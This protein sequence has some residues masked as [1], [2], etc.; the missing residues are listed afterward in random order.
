MAHFAELDTNNVVTRVIVVGNPDCLD[1]NGQESE[2]AGIAFCQSLF[3]ADTRWVQTSYNGN[4]RGNYAAVGYTYDEQLDAF[5]P[6]KPYPS[7]VLNEI[8]ITWEAPV[9]M[10]SDG[11]VYVWDEANQAW[12]TS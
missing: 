2:A 10:P 7:W 9:P 6:I 8:T 4:M 11:Q 3:G 5:I 1:E 12:V